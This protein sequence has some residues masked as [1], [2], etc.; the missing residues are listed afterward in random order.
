MSLEFWLDKL[1]DRLFSFGAFQGLFFSVARIIWWSRP[2]ACEKMSPVTFPNRLLSPIISLIACNYLFI[3]FPPSIIVF[4]SLTFLMLASGDGD[5]ECQISHFVTLLSSGDFL[6]R[7]RLCDNYP[8]SKGGTTLKYP[9]V[10]SRDGGKP[11]GEA[12][13]PKAYI[14]LISLFFGE[15]GEFSVCYR[16]FEIF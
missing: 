5:I 13:V 10:V 16:E 15:I 3:A 1:L 6:C 9:S 4:L 14:L 8:S 12:V 7:N 2:D 11:F